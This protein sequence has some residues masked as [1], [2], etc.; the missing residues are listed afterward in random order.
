MI[1]GRRGVVIGMAS[2]S[3]NIDLHP[4]LYDICTQVMAGA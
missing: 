1:A 3:Y 4:A 2:A